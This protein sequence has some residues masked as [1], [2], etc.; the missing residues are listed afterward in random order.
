MDYQL[1]RQITLLRNNCDKLIDRCHS[2]E[3]RRKQI[4]EVKELYIG[5]HYTKEL[6]VLLAREEFRLLEETTHMID[7]IQE[8][9]ERLDILWSESMFTWSGTAEDEGRLEVE[10]QAFGGKI[11]SEYRDFVNELY[12]AAT[13]GYDWLDFEE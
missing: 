1:R 10:K 3:L 8:S 5:N 6:Y 4:K 2:L 12:S 9:M 11:W 7:E 13:S